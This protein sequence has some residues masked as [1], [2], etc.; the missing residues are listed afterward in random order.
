[1]V[2]RRFAIAERDGMLP[3]VA[4]M[5]VQRGDCADPCEERGRVGGIA[6]ALD[7]GAA[8]FRDGAPSRL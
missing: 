7:R 5:Q 4:Y 6:A 2:H 1:M 8:A 3:R